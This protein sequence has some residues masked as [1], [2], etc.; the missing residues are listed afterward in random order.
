MEQTDKDLVDEYEL[1]QNT[2]KEIEDKIEKLRKEIINFTVQKHIN[3][4]YGTNKKCYV[5][6][7]QKVIYPEDKTTLLQIIK[8]KG[9]YERYSAINYFKLSPSII[10]GEADKDIIN[11][12]KK[13]K[14]FRVSL[15]VK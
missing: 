2:K 7:Y 10:R 11:L 6:E 3:L 12:V 5:K 14:D 8:E 9:L 15:T 1:L 4:I 13:E